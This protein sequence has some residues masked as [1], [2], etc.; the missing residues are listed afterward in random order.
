MGIDFSKTECQTT[1]RERRFG[2]HDAEDNSPAKIMLED[3]S[4]WNATV[5]H[6]NAKSILHVAIDH[7]IEIRREKGEMD[8]RCDCILVCE[9]TLILLE[10]KNKRGAWQTE[11]LAQIEATLRRLRQEGHRFYSESPKR[12]AIVANRKHQFPS[13]VESNKTKREYFMRQYRTRIQ[14]EAEIVM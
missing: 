5:I 3:E 7:R 4:S 12:K 2:I 11:G 1:T 14:F 9:D 10:L 8:K 13:F 6:D